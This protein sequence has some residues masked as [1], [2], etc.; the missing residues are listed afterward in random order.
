M[1]GSAAALALAA[2]IMG[3]GLPVRLRLLIAAADNSVSGNSFRP[4]DV[5]KSRA[6]LHVEIEDTDAEG[7][8]VLAD[9]L[10]V[11]D[12]DSPDHV[13]SFATLTG[14]ARVALGPDLPP[15]YSTDTALADHIVRMGMEIGDPSWPMPRWKPYDKMIKSK[16]GDIKNIAASPFAGSIIAALFLNRF[17][18]SAKHYTHFD[19]YGWVPE[20]LP[21]K[22]AG[23]EPQC[24]RA[25]FEYLKGA[26]SRP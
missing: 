5:L 8:L 23:G 12:E 13:F 1:G 16:L 25:V 22:P 18:K 26:Y 3:A 9:A 24:A 20:T 11:A 19:I 15:V 4:G 10:A 17:V 21:G 6:G 7:R 2:M 14:S